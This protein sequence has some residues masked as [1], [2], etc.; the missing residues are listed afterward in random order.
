M[1]RTT[2]LKQVGKGRIW[3]FQ[4]AVPSDVRPYVDKK[5]ALWS[6]SLRTDSRAQ[7]ERMVHKHI[8]ETDEI[9]RFARLQL[10]Q[11]GAIDNLP[12][13]DRRELDDAGGVR[14]LISEVNAD[15]LSSRFLDASIGLVDPD[16]VDRRLAQSDALDDAETLTRLSLLRKSI[17]EKAI[18]LNKV[19]VEVDAAQKLVRASAPGFNEVLDQFAQEGD[20]PD[21]TVRQ[22]RY[23]VR[24][25]IE[26]HGDLALDHVTK[27]HLREFANTIPNLPVS[28][29]AKCA[30]LPIREAIEATKYDGIDT[31]SAV[32]VTRHVTSI[33]TLA[34]YAAGVGMSDFDPFE[35]FR[36][37]QPKRNHSAAKRQQRLPF[38][39]DDLK[40]VFSVVERTMN[41][42]VDDYWIPYVALYQGARLE[43]ICQLELT[44]IGTSFDGVV[45]MDINDDGEPG[46]KVKNQASIRRMPI[47]PK[48]IE[49]GLLSHLK[50]SS[51]DIYLF[52]S[53]YSDERGRRGAAYGKRFSRLL[54]K[55][56]G[57]S[58]KR[59]VFHSFRHTWTDAAREAGLPEDVRL[60]LAGR[61][62]RGSEAGYGQGLSLS[63]AVN[64]L[65]KINPMGLLTSSS[66]AALQ[67]DQ[68]NP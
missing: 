10:D 14:G 32:T 54:R 61:E 58:D 1:T 47:H 18:L 19:G 30:A 45:F 20:L 26:L 33:R 38:R 4:R 50:R 28:H 17:A 67:R 7:A 15:L 22:Y 51:D 56:V 57:I 36:R 31:I 55:S 63:G 46:K 34:K 40:A 60:R 5:K 59:K 64:W 68:T 23:P 27:E 12:A 53:L 16:R 39:S 62:I 66:G 13:A 3:Y 29:K 9:I 65:S 6:V 8:A 25:F 24:R 21:Q 42:T 2:Y 41:S 44:D 11:D 48:L 43:E 52:S 37:R 35:G 49:M